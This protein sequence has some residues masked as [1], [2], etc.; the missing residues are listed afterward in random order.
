[1]TLHQILEEGKIKND[2]GELANDLQQDDH[3]IGRVNEHFHSTSIKLLEA[4]IEQM[5]GRKYTF[6][7]VD[8]GDGITSMENV[9][10]ETKSLSYCEGYNQALDHQISLLTEELLAI[11]KS[12]E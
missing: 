11:K 9:E 3:A 1:M 8:W 5:K 7:E 6:K 4:I 2:D 10:D 12:N